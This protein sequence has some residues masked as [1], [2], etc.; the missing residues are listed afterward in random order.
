[1]HTITDIDALLADL[2]ETRRR[3]YAITDEEYV[4]G[5]VGLAAA[6]ASRDGSCAGAVSMT[7]SK[8]DLPGWRADEIG[9][10]VRRAADD[11]S[12]MLADDRYP[13]P[14]PGV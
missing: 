6:F 8:G 9:R 5:V 14:A 12:I 3:G 1:V 7:G 11:V 13:G 2:A 10:A 4:E